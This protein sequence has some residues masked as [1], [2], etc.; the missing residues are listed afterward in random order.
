MEPS[1]DCGKL[2]EAAA[3][4]KA[5]AD[6]LA[7]PVWDLRALAVSIPEAWESVSTSAFVEHLKMLAH[8]IEEVEEELRQGET[9]CR[10][11]ARQVEKTEALNKA[12]GFNK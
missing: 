6:E 3:G 11:I 12:P 10:G 1:M 8:R 2:M 7:E 9:R 5:G 4:L